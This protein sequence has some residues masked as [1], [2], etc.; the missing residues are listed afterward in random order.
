MK[1][2]IVDDD[3]K[4]ARNLQLFLEV[5]YSISKADI[6]HADC[7]DAAKGL[8]KAIYFDALI[9]DV[10]L[11]KRSGEKPEA[12]I[13]IALLDQ[14]ARAAFL[15]KPEKIIGITAH[16]DDISS[17]RR[18]FETNCLTVIEAPMI[19]DE[20]KKK[21]GEA[22]RY[23]GASKI[24]RATSETKKVLVSVHGIRTFGQWQSR[25]RRL[26]EEHTD[27]VGFNTYKFGYFSSLLFLFPYFRNYQVAKFSKHLESLIAKNGNDHLIIFC[28][29]FGTFI[30]AN[31][32]K[33]LL[34]KGLS[35]SQTTLVLSGSVLTSDFDWTFLTPQN[36]FN[37]I[38][39]CGD[40][41]YVLWI[42]QAFVLG[43]GMAGKVGFDGFNGQ[44]IMNRYFQGG[45]SLYFDGDDFMRRYWIP[46]V[47]DSHKNLT[48]IDERN[49]NSLIHRSMEMIVNL[50]G[51]SKKIWYWLVALIVGTMIFP[52]L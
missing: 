22:L 39:E 7:V 34:A 42:S 25:L 1:L 19:S 9:L 18:E 43:T 47:S 52:L 4:R 32:L 20:W 3:L 27:Q 49:N 29:S 17:F 46:L 5:N 6:H 35:F 44:S 36:K 50:F 30:V 12:S 14:V 8:L 13:G 38:N 16:L 41:D 2:L 23:T 11:P 26:V 45:H 51:Q 24:S 15:K 40:R 31:A 33:S 21:I 10:V 48:E 37:I 28:H